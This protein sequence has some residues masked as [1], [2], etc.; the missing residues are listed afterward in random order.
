MVF[1]GD[2]ITKNWESVRNNPFTTK[3][4]INKGI[5]GNS[6]TQMLCRFTTDVV[7][8]KPKVVVV[9]AGINDLVGG[10]SEAV[11]GKVEANILQMVTESKKQGIK[12]VIV[13]V[14]PVGF[15]PTG[16]MKV[17]LTRRDEMNAAILLL[18][19]RLANVAAKT[20]STFLDYFK[21]LANEDGELSDEFNGD[22]VHLKPAAY[23]VLEPL[24]EKAIAAALKQ[25]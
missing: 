25:Q 19:G 2:S 7:E 17:F 3:G 23:A 20:D 6:S 15:R 5:S 22:N 11:I 10:S 9:L 12:V 24:A 13:S 18:N 1:L 8:L 4:Y 14:T 16:S 21:A